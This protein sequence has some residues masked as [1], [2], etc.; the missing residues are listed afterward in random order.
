MRGWLTITLALWAAGQTVSAQPPVPPVASDAEKQELAQ[1]VSEASTSGYDIIRALEAHLRKYPA[2]PLRPEILGLLAKASADTNDNARIVRYGEPVLRITPNDVVLLDAVSRALLSAGGKEEAARA[3]D[4]AKRFEDYVVRLPIPQGY[5]PVK[6]QEDHDRALA[7]ALLYQARA[8]NILGDYDEARRKAA[9]A[10]IAYPDEPSAREWSE[11]LEHQGKSAEAVQRLADALT[12]AD[13]RATAEDRAAARKKLGE[14]Y[15]SQ[16]GGSEAG[17]GE[18][19]LAAYDRTAET[20]AKRRAQLRE[21]DPNLGVSDPGRFTLSVLGG[22]KLNLATLRGKV[23]IFDFWATWCVP[24]RTQHP[25]YEEVK[26]RF[27][28][29]NDL[30]FLAVNTDED[31]ELVKPFMESQH[32]AGDVYYDIGLVRLLSVTSI[33]TTVIMD[34]AGRIVSRM[35]GFAGETFVEQLTARIQA[36]LAATETAGVN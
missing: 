28:G 2:T 15:R 11:A 22:G 36:A 6:N 1:A 14:L 30:V 17:L 29:R 4:Y 5:D 10:Y 9:L 8:K 31:R 21:M 16:H 24:C 35:N 23:L 18:E 33:P 19:I 26:K 3:L 32:W 34:K 27:N 7:R 12:I 13:P 20:L 25:L